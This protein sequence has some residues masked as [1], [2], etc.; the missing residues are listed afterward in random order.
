MIRWGGQ[1]GLAI[2]YL[3]QKYSP[4]VCNYLVLVLPPC[5]I[6]RHKVSSTLSPAQNLDR[7]IVCV[8][9]A[10]ANYHM[11]L[12]SL[13]TASV[14]NPDQQV[15]FPLYFFSKSVL[16]FYFQNPDQQVAFPLSFSPK[17][18]LSFSDPR[19]LRTS[20][21]KAQIEAFIRSRPL[22]DF[23]VLY[24]LGKNLNRYFFVEFVTRLS[25]LEEREGRAAK[26]DE[27]EGDTIIDMFIKPAYDE[28]DT[29]KKDQNMFIITKLASIYDLVW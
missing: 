9:I 15:A 21:K 20:P 18:N 7:L 25:D 17:S 10:V 6:F 24:Q 22:G 4:G 2:S 5:Y 13:Q 3:Y 8:Q 23:F 28:S 14:Q 12:F 1:T 27:D 19:Y 16:F 29:L 11:L 26:G